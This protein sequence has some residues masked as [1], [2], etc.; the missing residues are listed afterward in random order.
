M[1]AQAL[2][3]LSKERLNDLFGRLV[4]LLTVTHGSSLY[5]MLFPQNCF[6]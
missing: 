5:A 3:E 1:V 2:V 6:E 4:E